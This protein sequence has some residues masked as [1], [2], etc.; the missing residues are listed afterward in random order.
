MILYLFPLAVV[1]LNRGYPAVR[2]KNFLNKKSENYSLQAKSGLP[3]G[4]YTAH[5]LK[6]IFTFL[7]GWKKNKNNILWHKNYTKFKYQCQ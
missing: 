4:F 2:S 6:M 1:P 3:L 5:D 7:S